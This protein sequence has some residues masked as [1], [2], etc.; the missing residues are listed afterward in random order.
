M[1]AGPPEQPLIPQPPPTVTALRQAV[2][3]ITP[4]ALPA[5]TRELDQAADQARLGSDLAPL[6]RFTA[7]WAVHVQIHRRPAVSARL[8]ALEE[9][10]ET[11]DAEEVRRAAAE[12]G[13]ILDEARAA[14]SRNPR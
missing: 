5:F 13:R 3:Q 14:L 11:G 4:A 6:R 9:V 2:A 10:V 8:R 1:T 12:V 7:H